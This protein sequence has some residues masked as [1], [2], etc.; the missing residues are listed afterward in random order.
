MYFSGKLLNKSLVNDNL[1]Q[2]VFGWV[3][4]FK[5]VYVGMGV[6]L[7]N[8]LGQK[9]FRVFDLERDHLGISSAIQGIRIRVRK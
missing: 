2:H 6:G 5:L 4:A 8:D 7:G 1:I 9:D 3:E